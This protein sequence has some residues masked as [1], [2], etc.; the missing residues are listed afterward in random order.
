VKAFI[1]ALALIALSVPVTA[2]PLRT[3]NGRLFIHARINGVA[4]EGLLD[5]G[6]EMTLVDPQL[7][8]RASLPEG[9]PQTLR[10]SGGETQARLVEGVTVEALGVVMHP[11]AVVVSDLSELSRRL[12]KHATQLI[13]GRE[14]FDAARLRI[15]IAGGEIATEA[16]SSQPAGKRLP[17]TGHAGIEAVPVQVNGVAAQAE[18]DLGNGSDVLVSRAMA[19]RLKLKPVG[20]KQGGGIGGSRQRQLVRLRTLDV[21]GKRFRNVLAA[22]DEQPNANDLNIG[23]A[24]LRR[25]L[26]V[27]DFANRSVWL[28]P[29]GARR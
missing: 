15:D 24:I 12:I 29:A 26:I 25:F 7:A 17:L 27:T 21:A 20:T 1:A 5:S 6:A 3:I 9:S 13:V 22:I 18:F 14:L 2:E 19:Q 10:G 8:A 11:E 23:T 28:S 16:K 4:S